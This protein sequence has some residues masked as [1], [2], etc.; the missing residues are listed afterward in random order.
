MATLFFVVAIS[1]ILI[2]LCDGKAAI[3]IDSLTHQPPA[4]KEQLSHSPAP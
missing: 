2:I 3:D 1:R 4:E